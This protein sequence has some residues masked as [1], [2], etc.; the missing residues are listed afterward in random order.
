MRDECIVSEDRI[1]G[2]IEEIF[3]W[4]VRR[5][6]Y[7]ADRKAEEFSA[8]RFRELGLEDVRLEPVPLPLWEP[9][10]WSLQVDAAGERF[11]LRCFPL[12]HA[13]PCDELELEPWREWVSRVTHEIEAELAQ[14]GIE[15]W[16]AAQRRKLFRWAGHVA[17]RD[18]N[19]W[20]TLV[21][22]WATEAG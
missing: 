20:S 9:R 10:Q 1:H 4:G 5:P 22:D 12:P 19:R 16:V 18:D 15:D 2:W 3:G 13:A 6:G 7:P 14:W 21:L 8:Q 17:R 11:E